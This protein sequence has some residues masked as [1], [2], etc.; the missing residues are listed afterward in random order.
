M[1]QDPYQSPTP[2]DT[3]V[4]PASFRWSRVGFALLAIFVFCVFVAI[5]HTL[6]TQDI[7][8]NSDEDGREFSR[9]VDEK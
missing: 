6:V 5:Y 3:G 4:D 1:N 2:T 9:L 8:R 7:G